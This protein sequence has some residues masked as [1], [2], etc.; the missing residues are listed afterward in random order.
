MAEKRDYYDVLGV[1]RSASQ[2]EIKKAYRGLAKKYHPDVSK[3]HDAEEKFKEMSEAYEVL[4]DEGKRQL[5]DQYGHAG[6]SGQFTGGGFSWDDFTHF[7]DIEDLFGGEFFGRNIFDVFVGGRRQ[8]RSGPQRGADL[9]HDLETTLEDAARGLKAEIS[10]PRQMKCGACNGSGAEKGSKPRTCPNCSGTGQQRSERR[11]PFGFFS[12]ITACGKCNGRG[13]FIEKPCEECNGTGIVQQMQR[14]SLKIPAGVNSGSHL[15]VR[16]EGDAGFRG[17]PPG[18]LYVVITVKPHNF[19]VR[20]GDDLYCEIPL[21]FSQAA[22]G[23]AIDVP[24]L[25]GEAKLKIPTG[26][27][28][29][30][31]FRLRGEGMPRL[32]GSSKGDQM[33]RVRVQTP[34]KLSKRE[35][36]LFEELSGFERKEGFFDRVRSTFS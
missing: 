30:T 36:E 29:G 32:G 25:T 12:T 18:D 27:Q 35:R 4:A 28:T 34:K 2:S 33:C 8:R 19:F 16:G 17:G 26:T 23:S 14:L 6:V 15:R 9:R 21:T 10:I 20:D 7:S 1:G 5:Y 24:T 22:I 3:S 11:T 13:E 31:V